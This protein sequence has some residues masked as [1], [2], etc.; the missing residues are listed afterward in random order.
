MAGRRM[1][2]ILMGSGMVRH[3][4][5]AWG[6]ACENIWGLKLTDVQGPC[7]GFSE[8]SKHCPAMEMGEHIVR[9]GH[10]GTVRL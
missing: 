5:D 4:G 10:V 8:S 9:S 2:P 3:F 7:R 1:T 6:H